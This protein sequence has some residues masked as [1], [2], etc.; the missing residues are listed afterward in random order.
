MRVKFIEEVS[1]PIFAFTIKDVKGTE[2]GGTNTDF[3]GVKTGDFRAGEVV[4]IAFTQRINLNA[5]NYLLSLGCVSS[6]GGEL[7]VFDR[8]H[9]FQPF[10]ILIEKPIVGLVDLGTELEISRQ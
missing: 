8:R 5:G 7:E 2:I 6:K 4:E 3:L 1:E 10:Q 9:D